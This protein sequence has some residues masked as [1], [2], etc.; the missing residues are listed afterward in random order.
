MTKGK[1]KI[2]LN[3]MFPEEFSHSAMPFVFYFSSSAMLITDA[4]GIV[5]EA[6]P[7]FFRMT[8]YKAK[9]VLG[10]RPDMI[11]QS[12]RAHDEFY[13]ELWKTVLSEG[14]WIGRVWDKKK[15]GDL[16][17]VILAIQEIQI[18]NSDTPL[19][20]S[21]YNETSFFSK[22]EVGVNLHYDIDI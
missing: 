8:G 13:N 11:V 1:S 21:I 15:N 14:Q 12:G 18:K 5:L 7:A 22:T 10:K 9:E 6:N 2:Q 17:P 4:T 20:L 16:F 19:F 3:W